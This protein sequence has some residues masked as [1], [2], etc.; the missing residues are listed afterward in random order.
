MG[1]K[2]YKIGF[3]GCGFIAEQ[4]VKALQQV[5]EIEVTA[6][7]A[8]HKENRESFIDKMG[9]AKN[10]PCFQDYHEMLAMDELDFVSISAPNRVHKEMLFAAAEAGKHVICEKPLANNLKDVDDMVE[11]MDKHKL[12]FAV[13]HE[14]AFYP[15]NLFVRDFLAKRNSGMTR[16]A[17]LGAFAVGKWNLTPWRLDPEIS[18]GGVVM[19]EGIHLCHLAKIF[20]GKKKPLRVTGF[21]DKLNQYESRVEDTGSMTFEFNSGFAQANTSFMPMIGREQNM[22]TYSQGFL[23]DDM[24]VEMIFKGSA[25]GVYSPVE[26]VLMTAQ[27]GI[28]EYPM[29]DYA[30][31]L[32]KNID[33]FQRLYLDF[34]ESVEND[35]DP[36]VDGKSARDATEMVMA[37]YES[38]A[39]GRTVGLPLATDSPI[40]TKGALGIKDLETVTKL[41]D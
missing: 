10:I 1:K 30:W 16:F 34:I 32:A 33:A 23:T 36:Y 19:D 5:P 24:S 28:Q 15:E 21:I 22:R 18:G 25:E 29:P 7:A 13:Y 37:V 39:R 11:I 20:F 6:L 12:K 14:A 40:Y 9:L 38:A 26:K 41:L 27:D 31:P 4:Q 2:P 8:R 35:R 3:I 17:W